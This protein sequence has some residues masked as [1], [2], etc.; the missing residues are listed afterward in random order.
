MILSANFTDCEM[1]STPLLVKLSRTLQKINFM[2]AKRK[3]KR[4]QKVSCINQSPKANNQSNAM[5]F[6]SANTEKLRSKVINFT[7]LSVDLAL[8]TNRFLFV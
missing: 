7:V 8:T 2:V 5:Q 6:S 3:G 1:M 4:R